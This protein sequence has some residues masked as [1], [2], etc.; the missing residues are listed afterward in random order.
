MTSLAPRMDWTAANL[1]EA[2][3]LFQQRL[4]LFFTTQ[5]V[6]ADD[7]AAHILLQVGEEGL[8][9]YNSWQLSEADRSDPAVIFA[10]F[11]EQLEPADNFRVS[12]LKLM[13]FRQRPEETL[14]EFINRCHLQAQ[15]CDFSP[16][17]ADER[18]IELIIA[19]TPIPEF[20]AALLSKEKGFTVQQTLK[21]G[22]TY[23]ATASHVQELK[24]MTHTPSAAMHGIRMTNP[25]RNCGGRHPTTPRERCP[26]FGA[27]CRSCGKSNHWA[28]FCRSSKQ[29]PYRPHTPNAR[30]L[31]K[32]SSVPRKPQRYPPRTKPRHGSQSF[33]SLEVT[34]EDTNEPSLEHDLE[35]LT[36]NQVTIS[37][38]CFSPPP[39]DEA[40]AQLQIKRPNR[41][42]ADNLNLKVDTGAQGNTLPLRLYRQMF[43]TLL[44]SD[45]LPVPRIAA[46][47]RNA[48]L[49]AYNGSA[50]QCHGVISFPC[51][52][53][54]SPWIDTTFYVV[55]VPGSA[56]IGL[57]SCERLK[58]VTLHCSMQSS[59]ATQDPDQ[60]KQP[61]PI[62]S[63]QDLKKCYPDQF[64]KIGCIPGPV[65]LIVDPQAQPHVDPPRKTPIA[66][67]DAIKNELDSMER[68]EIIRKVTEPTDW[69]SSLVYSKK[70]DGSIRVCLDPR[71][72][73]SALKRPHHKTPT[74]EELTHHFTGAKIFSKLDAK[75]GYW[76]VQ[77]DTDSQLLTTFQS[78]FGRYCFQ[79]LPFGLS[80]SQDLFQRKMDQILEQV[81]GAI[82]IA[83]DIVVYAK[84]A[85]EHD[86][87]IHSLMET[88]AKN[89]LV[90]NSSKCTI[91]TP[92]ITFFGMTYDADGVHPDPEKICDLQDMPIP[93]CKKELQTFLGF[94]QY[95]SP[96]IPNLAEKSSILRDLLK[97]DVPFIWDSNHQSAFDNLKATVTSTSTL[98]YFDTSKTPTLQVDAS[99]RGLG[100]SLLQD[101][102]P[103]AFASKSL[104]DA[105][106]RYACIER[107]LLAI[108]FGVQRFHTYLY[109]RPFKVTTDHKPLVMIL[110]KPLT[111]AP[112][113]LQ[114]ML[115][116]LQGYNFSIEHHPGKSMALADTLSRLP[117]P[118]NQEEIDLDIRV[119]LIRFTPTR[120]GSI[121]QETKEDKTL[122]RLADMIVTGW[123]DTIQDV[124]ASIRSYWAYRDELSV[125]DGIILK[126]NRVLIPESLQPTILTQLHYEHQ[127]IEKTRL[128][129]KEAVFWNNINKDIENVI[130]A[131][132]ICPEPRSY[133]LRANNGQVLRRNR[134]HIRDVPQHATPEVTT[135]LGPPVRQ[136]VPL[137]TAGCQRARLQQP[138]MECSVHR[139]PR[140]TYR[141]KS[142][143]AIRAPH[144]LDL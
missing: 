81:D 91:K 108:V 41:A 35:H 52:Y 114:R 57:P 79:R 7:K 10:K 62:H 133:L 54:D 60:T 9:R 113:R 90:L 104:S 120:T 103:V 19:S 5:K 65:K 58:V 132:P 97:Q 106:T 126:G 77:L 71:R 28:K 33:H 140:D 13:R 73:N 66:L 111:A 14:D 72:L 135:T 78:P 67:K 18:L 76:S 31:Q 95:L 122:Q 105:E 118:S 6:H 117:T 53:N 109:G 98:K 92:S 2:F 136:A 24:D 86:A 3:A 49:T 93:T 32:P 69:V 15:K 83:D 44:T 36:F 21:L 112:P 119:D 84:T 20:Q 40:F 56:I 139:P 30:A 74:V 142:G 80:V 39:R 87:I 59:Q 68:N 107:E 124:P 42:L 121:R 143:R 12:R 123:P 34:S 48:R 50:I 63:I 99:I 25:C 47:A 102:Q 27:T 88:A 96:F 89:G 8:R 85:K 134:V 115:L 61:P 137:P 127:G 116:K 17:E 45:G 16:A 144:R 110:A 64:D 4:E 1:A 23:E 11:K 29:S 43:P 128:R 46:K 130:K 141:T 22:R 26:A 70:K 131:C 38:M 82:G 94:I 55:D 129:A 101:G 51:K 125:E 37:S 138:D 75:A 100:A